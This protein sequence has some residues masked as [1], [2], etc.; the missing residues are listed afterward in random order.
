MKV[1]LIQQDLGRRTIKYPLFPLGLCYIATALKD[2]KVKIFDPNIYNFP[3]SFEELKKEVR[4]FQPDIIGISIRNVDTTQR[5]DP[6]VHLKTVSPTI[7]IVKDINPESRIM[8]GGSGFSIFAEDIMERIPQVDFGIYLEGEESTP[9]LL[10]NLE[11]PE[12]VKGIFFRKNGEVKFTGPRPLPD[13]ATLPMPR[14]DPE[15]IDITKYKGPLHNII[16]IQSKRG[17]LYKCTYC[18]YV[19]LNGC[20]IRLRDPIKVVDEIEY[21]LNNY[22][23]K[24]FT[25]VDSIFNVPEKHAIAIC[26]EIISRKLNKDIEWG[27][28]CSLRNFSEEF[29]RLAKEA[30]CKHI[31]F[32]PDAATDKGLKVLKKGIT[33]E[34]I[35]R[36]LKVARK[37]KGVAVGY[38]FFCCYPGQ[39]L[40]G[41]LKTVFFLFKIS[42]LLPGRGG[43]DVGW[44][45]IEPHTELYKTAIEEGFINSQTELLPED[46]KELLKLFYTP[47]SQRH[48]TLFMDFILAIIETVLKPGVKFFFRILSRVRGKRSLYDS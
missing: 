21:L 6:F 47:P 31:G 17:C 38:S 14:R 34:D 18:S 28:W 24:G 10:D 7:Q 3:E 13:F 33:E 8:V 44:I 32:S 37:V 29:L 35:E 11:E 46:E 23:I 19:F 22:N 36:S 16:G 1:L 20:N 48:F 9:E 4:N 26:K 42:L 30:G 41:V 5:R 39:S 12:K 15:V 25:F 45:R 2:H 27:A 40:K 43:G